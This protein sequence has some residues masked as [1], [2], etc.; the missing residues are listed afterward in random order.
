MRSGIF[1]G[2]FTSDS[3]RLHFLGVGV[4][5]HTIQANS[6]KQIFDKSEL[7]M[8]PLKN[9]NAN[10]CNVGGR[11]RGNCNFGA[12]VLIKCDKR[13]GSYRISTMNAMTCMDFAG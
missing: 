12:G 4:A 8:S 10:H 11:T 6:Q 13:P 7:E 9:V 5:I 2:L 1:L 3:A